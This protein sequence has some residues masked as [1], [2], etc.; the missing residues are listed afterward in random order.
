MHIYPTSTTSPYPSPAHYHD[1]QALIHHPQRMAGRGE[2]P[3]D[4]LQQRV[5][6]GDVKSLVVETTAKPT[7]SAVP[8]SYESPILQRLASESSAVTPS[9]SKQRWAKLKRQTTSHL[10]DAALAVRDE[11]MNTSSASVAI[12]GETAPGGD[13]EQG[14]T[15]TLVVP[16]SG[17]PRRR[18]QTLP[19]GMGPGID[20]GTL[21]VIC[22][23][24]APLKSV[25]L[26]S[27]I[28]I[29]LFY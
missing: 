4:R 22:I 8:T 2:S 6:Q 11:L 14:D 1:K 16:L 29:P 15:A 10:A 12:V 25:P 23:S 3:L 20:R 19:N 5:R 28:F 9:P 18:R 17:R 7:E 27:F 24:F 21:P 13:E 26:M